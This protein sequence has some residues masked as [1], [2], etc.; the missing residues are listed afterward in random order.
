MEAAE[1]VNPR[2]PLPSG[3][4]IQNVQDVAQRDYLA[5]RAI[6]FGRP[7]VDYGYEATRADGAQELRTELITSSTDGGLLERAGDLVDV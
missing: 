7:Y 3:V 4:P 5:Q 1:A 2:C 6:L